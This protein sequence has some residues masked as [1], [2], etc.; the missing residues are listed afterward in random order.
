MP[1]I[2]V[3]LVFMMINGHPMGSTIGLQATSPGCVGEMAAI[4]GINL[5]LESSGIFYQ[6]S[7]E[8]VSIATDV[9]NGSSP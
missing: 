1:D 2:S 8:T 7:C 5:S 6:A 4:Q 3:L 9:I